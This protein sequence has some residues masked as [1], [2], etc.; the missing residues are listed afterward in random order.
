[1]KRASRGKGRIRTV[2]DPGTKE[3]A[4]GGGSDA[5]QLNSRRK[6][7]NLDTPAD[8]LQVLSPLP[9]LLISSLLTPPGFPQ[10]SS[11]I[12]LSA[13]YRDNFNTTQI[14]I[15]FGQTLLKLSWTS[16]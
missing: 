3:P 2:Q 8:S 11:L 16:G 9:T 7:L 1:M 13:L 5:Q 4:A 15:L 6:K 14:K 12:H 10:K